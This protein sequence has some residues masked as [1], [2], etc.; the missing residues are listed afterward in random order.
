MPTASLQPAMG[1]SS[2][3]KLLFE[4]YVYTYQSTNLA[5]FV[6][7]YPPTHMSNLLGGK[8]NLHTKNS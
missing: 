3:L 6:C 2:S 8:Y 7:P 5:M 4:K 1:M